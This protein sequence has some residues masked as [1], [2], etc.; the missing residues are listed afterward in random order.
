MGVQFELN[1]LVIK[2]EFTILC[3]TCNTHQLFTPFAINLTAQ[4]QF[5]MLYLVE[6]C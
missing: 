1:G 6:S 2:I 5:V 3:L 4:V